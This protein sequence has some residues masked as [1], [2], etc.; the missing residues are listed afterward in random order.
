[1][2]INRKWMLVHRLSWE[3][4]RGPI[5]KGLRVCHSCDVRNCVRPDHLWLGTDADNIADRDMKG[6]QATGFAI[7]KGGAKRHGE[8]NGRAKLTPEQVADIRRRYP[9]RFGRSAGVDRRQILADEFN[10]SIAQLYRIV[11]GK[12]WIN[13]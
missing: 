8:N 12:H 3:L 7:G 4:H 1:M 5:P 9:T 11:K 10:I 13:P 2:M 6:R